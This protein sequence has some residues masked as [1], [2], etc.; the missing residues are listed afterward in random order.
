M[1]SL[2]LAG[3]G[4]LGLSI[5]GSGQTVTKDYDVSGF[6]RIA[7][8]NA[9]QV[10]IKQ[11]PEHKVA[12]TVDDNLLEYLDVTTSGETLRI[13]MQPNLNVRNG[14]LKAAI[15]LPDLTGLDL[16]G[17]THTT[18]SGFSS[19]KPLEVEVSGASRLRGEI[20]SGDARYEVS[21][22]SNIDLQGSAGSLDVSASGASEANFEKCSSSNIVAHASGASHITVT[23]NGNLE[24]DASGAS[25]VRY[26]GEPA[27]LRTNA[28]GASSVRRK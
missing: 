18:V 19:D 10:E 4:V 13:R 24:A 23:A 12:V 11:G 15:T 14:T 22:A 2:A 3:C 27:K 21:G 8:G 25:S 9:F 16:S 28:S 17:A 5:T 26:A 6:S 1:T 7:V 20:K